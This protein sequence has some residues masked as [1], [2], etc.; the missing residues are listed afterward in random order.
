VYPNPFRQVSTLD[1]SL[2]AAEDLEICVYN[3]KGQ[4]VKSL[5]N[6]YQQAGEHSQSWNGRDEQGQAVA[7]GIYFYRITGSKHDSAHKTILI[8]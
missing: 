4:L 2:K 8:R 7:N 1:Y 6:G 5:F 3:L